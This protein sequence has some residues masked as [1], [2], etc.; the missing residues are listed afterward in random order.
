M[1]NDDLMPFN[2]QN[3]DD[4]DESIIKVIGVGGGGGNAVNNMFQEG[5]ENVVFIICNTDEQV[6]KKS[7]VPIKIQI[8]G[9]LTSGLGAGNNPE[10]GRE[11]AKESIQEITSI[12]EKKTKMAFITAGM[13]GG[14]G[15]G[16]APIIAEAAKNLGILTVAIVT[17]PFLFEGEKRIVQAIEGINEMKKH[18]DSM[19]IINNQKILDIYGDLDLMAAFKKADQIVTVAAK[20]IAEI[21][22]V[23]GTV[24]VDFADVKS[25]MQNSGVAVMGTGVGEGENRAIEAAK[26]AISSPLLNNNDIKG[27]K[28]LLVNIVSPTKNPI[29]ALETG[30]V[31]KY[32]QTE[33][34]YK[35]NLIWGVT[36][37]ENMPENQAV[38]T[39]VATQFDDNIIPNIDDLLKDYKND[40][41]EK[42]DKIENSENTT[43]VAVDN[44]K[45]DE[46]KVIPENE[47][48]QIIEDDDKDDDDDDD[49]NDDDDDNGSGT[50][51]E[52]DEFSEI[53]EE[54][55]AEKIK[56]IKNQR[57]DY[58]DDNVVNDY[59]RYPAFKRQQ[60]KI[61]FY[62]N[63]KTSNKF[64][65]SNSKN[66][67]LNPMVD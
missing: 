62:N 47:I 14:T 17:I 8:G 61:N 60:L 40:N 11:A 65:R 46:N 53:D 39:V 18:V 22:T 52:K 32:L 23:P 27:A 24:N 2:I 64:N 38:V 66:N 25:V 63:N 49:N 45:N 21:I 16:A 20:G 28:N 10:V 59:E 54:E 9:E 7:P 67:Y 50:L 1:N 19:I 44:N 43:E 31:N 55:L 12:L 42:S 6:L 5:I 37:D 33:A 4:K 3:Y 34:G 29:L 30:A 57:F 51:F 48:E 56:N 58:K 13:G 36:Y 15:T 35:A 41:S 26:N